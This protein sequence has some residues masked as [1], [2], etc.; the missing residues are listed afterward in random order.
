MAIVAHDAG[1]GVVVREGRIIECVSAGQRPRTPDFSVFDAREH[2]VVPG[3]INTHHHL[4][5]T[6]TRAHPKA[7]NKA[8]FPWLQALYPV[9]A[10][11]NA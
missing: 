8:L 10:N 6:L 3:L 4:Y 7:I 11:I 9:W 1:A 2:V 5:Q